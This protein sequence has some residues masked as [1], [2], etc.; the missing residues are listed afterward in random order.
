LRR[1]AVKQVP[2][3]REI[4]LA[5]V[6]INYKHR[7]AWHAIFETHH[8]PHRSLAGG[9]ERCLLS[10]PRKVRYCIRLLMWGRAYC[11]WYTEMK[12]AE[13]GCRRAPTIERRGRSGR[14]VSLA[15][16]DGK[17][18]PLL[19]SSADGACGEGTAAATSC[20]CVQM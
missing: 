10:S 8:I 5:R 16:C 13:I 15:T 17:F 4:E 3:H 9:Q 11:Q 18:K 1:T 7:I 6:A 14:G 2:V 20:S 12:V 19:D